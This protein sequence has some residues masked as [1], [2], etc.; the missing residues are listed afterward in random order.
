MPSDLPLG[1]EALVAL[2][3]G[4][5]GARAA[6]F[7]LQG[8]RWI[9]V[10]RAYPTFLPQ[11]GWA[12]QDARAWR[13]AALSALRGAVTLVGPHRRLLA[14]G[15]TGQCPSI[16][17]LDRRDRP[18]GP[19]LTYRDNRAVAEAAWLISRFGAEE[20]HLRTGHLSAAFHIAPK[21]LWLRAHR[22][23]EFEATQTWLQPRDL[24]AF[25][26]T[27]ERATEGSHAPATLL[28]DLR[29][30]RWDPEL[31]E[32]VGVD[33]GHLPRLGR[34]AEVVGTVR[35][36]LAAH[37]GLRHPLPVVL[38]GADSQTCALGAGVV[39]PG[40]VSEMAGSSTCL[41]SAVAEPLTTLAI[42]HYRHVVGHGYTTETGL[43]TSGAAV[44]W[45]A[46]AGH[47]MWYAM[48]GWTEACDG[49][50][51]AEGRGGQVPHG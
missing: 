32:A 11:P 1:D 10:R 3:V 36:T 28:Y 39:G 14:L 31:L 43:N 15:L 12:E 16:V 2:D 26:L 45:A 4:T 48:A 20:L 44:A 37:L 40:P 41:N 27:G 23:A 7:D 21:L 24:A 13:V 35:P 9:E 19:G 18:V 29:A 33:E 38:G 8:H 47:H 50:T 6:V 49:H 34:S 51:R 30:G 25:V 42:T 5:T 46:V 22:R 17:G